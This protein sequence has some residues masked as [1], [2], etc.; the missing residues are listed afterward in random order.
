M[1]HRD[2]N[3][4]KSHPGIQREC[5]NGG[6]RD[7]TLEV[8]TCPEGMRD[9]DE[10]DQRAIVEKSQPSSVYAYVALLSKCHWD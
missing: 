9:L 3:Y 2:S 6:P 7:E 5:R 10:Q 4:K 8:V 1:L